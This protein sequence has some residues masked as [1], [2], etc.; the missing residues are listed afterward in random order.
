MR[1]LFSSRVD[2][3]VRR[4]FDE[5]SC[6]YP[7]TL[8]HCEPPDC[9][10]NRLLRRR[11]KKTSKLRVT[12]LCVGNSPVTGEF[13]AQMASNSEFFF[14]LMT[15]S[16]VYRIYVAVSQLPWDRRRGAGIRPRSYRP[17]RT[18]RS[19]PETQAS[20]RWRHIIMVTSRECPGV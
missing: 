1:V 3:R 13:P 11:S 10:V 4:H 19:H 16:C 9:L 2:V 20:S 15:S 6:R 8:Y 17:D 12:G 7:R 14:H 5:G 18:G